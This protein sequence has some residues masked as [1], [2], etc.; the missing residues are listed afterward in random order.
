MATIAAVVMGGS[1]GTLAR[2]GVDIAIERRSVSLFVHHQPI[3]LLSRRL[4]DRSARRPPSHTSLA[5]DRPRRRVLRRLYDVL[6]LCAGT[7]G[8]VEGKA[9]GLAL[10]NATA[11]VGLGMLAV[12]VGARVGRLL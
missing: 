3:R 8:L 12:L 9:L 5:A 11:S 10:L 4:V 1:L 2:Y 7:Y 6:D